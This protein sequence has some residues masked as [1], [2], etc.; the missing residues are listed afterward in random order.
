VTERSSNGWPVLPRRVGGAPPTLRQWN[1]PSV[2]LTLTAR[3]GSA[4]FLLA[5]FALW[6]HEAIEPLDRPPA[7][8]WGYARRLIRGG[9]TWSNHASGTAID[10]NATLHPLGERGTLRGAQVLKLRRRL[11]AADY[12]ASCIGW[13]GDWTTRADEMHY[14]I[15]RPL[16]A[17]EEVAANLLS[18]WRGRRVLAANPGAKAVI[19]S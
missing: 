3:D 1:I 15:Q 19:L 8:D 14:E 2:D 16:S 13:G 10:L 9:S 18:T 4:G 7:D 11:W 12:Y 6:Y 5:H 17:C